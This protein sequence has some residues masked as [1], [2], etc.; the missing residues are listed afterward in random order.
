MCFEY[1]KLPSFYRGKV[2]SEHFGQN[3]REK[4]KMRREYHKVIFDDRSTDRASFRPDPI[5]ST[6]SC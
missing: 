5:S 3:R 2:K 4:N 6:E 1:D